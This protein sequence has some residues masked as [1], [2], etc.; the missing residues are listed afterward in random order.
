MFQRLTLPHKLALLVVLAALPLLL[1]GGLW[2]HGQAEAIRTVRN[3]QAGA[4]VAASLLAISTATHSHLDQSPSWRAGR[5]DAAAARDS[6][7][8]EISR[9]AAR[10]VAALAQ[11]P[12][13]ALTTE[14]Q[15]LADT[16]AVLVRTDAHDAQASLAAHLAAFR[17]MAA[18]MERVGETSELLYD[19]EASTYFL[20]TVVID[21][22][23]P[24]SESAAR[25]RALGVEAVAG[26]ASPMSDLS[27]AWG[28]V[29]VM[30]SRLDALS[31]KLD[32]LKRHGAGS[33]EVH[34][35]AEALGR[36]YVE[37]ARQVLASAPNPG[38]AAAFAD[39]GREVMDAIAASQQ[40]VVGELGALL[41]QRE[42]AL[43]R[44]RTL[45]VAGGLACATLVLALAVA[46]VRGTLRA[47]VEVSRALQAAAD[48]NLTL[49]LAIEGCDEFATMARSVNLMRERLST[50]VRTIQG[51]A[52]AVMQTGMLLSDESQSLAERT[53]QQASSVEE[54]AVSLEQVSSSVQ[55]GAERV[56]QVEQLFCNVAVTV[57]GGVDQMQAAVST[58]EG[59]E[60]GSRRV[61]EIVGV[62]DGIAFQTNILALNA[63]V[64]AARAGESG[65]GFAVVA[66]EVRMLAQRSSTAAGEIRSLIAE[67]TA[68][69]AAGCQQIRSARDSLSELL[70]DV[71]RVAHALGDLAMSAREQS[72]AVAEVSNDVRDIGSATHQ[73]ASS[74]VRASA[75]AQ[76]LG[77]QSQALH[78]ALNAIRVTE[79]D[80]VGAASGD[81]VWS[82]PPQDV[83]MSPSSGGSSGQSAGL[84]IAWSG[85]LAPKR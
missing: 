44:R 81:A 31:V 20:A 51:D 14:G 24:W 85:S 45:A 23:L 47:T 66:S 35:R 19:P 16:L 75:M 28:P 72:E 10:S 7:G 6:A 27:T 32:A 41:A 60:A 40:A 3:E 83:A 9:A 42:A 21:H 54:S 2:L 64:E 52:L 33:S 22:L 58:V 77:E 74:V 15:R 37:R 1:F 56:Q 53:V 43:E 48:G 34:A 50:M 70:G 29:E 69:V 49:P 57:D 4:D 26:G 67:S 13:W 8:Q 84:P 38:D 46:M 73:T 68:Q 5:S 12:A 76:A 71:Q 62:I 39:A 17:G 30:A 59:I 63:A 65:R 11:R 79:A 80:D 36:A 78:R 55:S 25:V 82:L 61:A 18:L